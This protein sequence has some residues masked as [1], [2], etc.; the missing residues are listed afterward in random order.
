MSYSCL[1]SFLQH[2]EQIGELRRITQ[3]VSPFVE[4][5]KLAQLEA[6]SKSPTQSDS[7]GAFDPGREQ[8]GGQALFIENI[9]GCDFPLVINTFGSYFR[10]EQALGGIG[11]EEIAGKISQLA[12]AAPPSGISELLS[13]AKQFKPLLNLKP[14][15]IKYRYKA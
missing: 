6:T 9:T 10:M 3:F 11:F 8:I 1:Q 14:K 7:A 5:T 4:V 2:L 13:M 15:R 12:N